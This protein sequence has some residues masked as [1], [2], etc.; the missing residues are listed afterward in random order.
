MFSDLRP[1]Q[2]IVRDC[3]RKLELYETRDE[4]AAHEHSHF[5]EWICDIE[6]DDSPSGLVFP[7]EEEYKTHLRQHNVS[8]VEDQQLFL[9][10]QKRLSP[11]PFR[12]C[13]F[14]SDFDLQ[15]ISALYE[16][17]EN[18]YLHIETSQNLQKHIALHLFQFSTLALLEPGDDCLESLSAQTG[19]NNP[20]DDEDSRHLSSVS[21]TSFDHVRDITESALSHV[22]LE[23]ELSFVPELI[24]PEDWNYISKEYPE[25]ASENDEA[26]LAFTQ[27]FQVQQEEEQVEGSRGWK[28]ITDVRF[29]CVS[30]FR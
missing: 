29:L 14:C 12:F 9:L 6:H 25:S 19:V 28:L 16:V 7:S 23:G 13:P 17:V 8:S 15:D 18:K 5:Y 11:F 22:T 24:E 21:L 2:C 26:L 20:E 1:Y 4:W 27:R 10:T 30:R 3:T